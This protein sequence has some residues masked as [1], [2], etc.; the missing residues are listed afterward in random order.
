MTMHPLLSRF[1]LIADTPGNIQRLR[2]LVVHLAISGRLADNVNDN[3]STR[4]IVESIA[5]K[6]KALI[7]LGKIKKQRIFPAIDETELPVGCSGA[8]GFER[9]ENIA[10]LEKGLTAIQRTK[11][12]EYPLVTTGESRSNASH[13]D[14][15]GCAAIIP[16]VSSTGHGNASLK[17][18]HYQEGKF[19]M[20]NILCAAFPI[21]DKLISAR[22]IFEYLTA[23]KDE[24][25]VSRMIGT[26][27]VS[28]TLG[29]IG[30]VPIPIVPPA[31]QRRVDELMALCDHFE[32]ALEN[33]E[34]ARNTLVTASLNR[35]DNAEDDESLH[36][37]AHFHFNHLDRLSARTDHIQKLR[38]SI[39]SLAVRGRLVSQD[40]ADEPAPE[41]LKRIDAEKAR[42]IKQGLL[43]KE[44][45]LAPIDEDSVPFVVPNGW[46]WAKIGTCSLLT[47]YGTSVRSDANA[48][49]VPVLAMGDIQDGRVILHGRKKVPAGIDDL[50]QLFLKRFDLLYNRTNSAEL[51]GKTGIFLGSDDKYTFA[52]YL[53]RIRFL[54][55]LTSPVYANL[56]M[57]A[58]YFRVTQIV[59]ELQ[60]QCG[61]ANVNGTKLRNMLIPFPPLAEQHRIVTKVHELMAI[62]DSLESQIKE[63]QAKA[64]SLLESVLHS[65]LTAGDNPSASL[66]HNLGTN[67]LAP[68]VLSTTPR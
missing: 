7:K 22:F 36:E 67:I 62:C 37:R 61:Q 46:T 2:K 43:R 53:I 28:L 8:N 57:N 34:K 59:P 68:P 20:G 44:K 30:E 65:T 29:K 10:M 42:L 24:L 23:F 54:N 41:L 16:M 40:P 52:S 63:V 4:D 55:N 3:P 50:P 66:P 17:R 6:K 33:R 38:E 31:V 60:Q 5:S 32:E 1:E 11:P 47:E 48:G 27:N 25:L 58:P 15:D 49:G 39:L 19:A 45:P 51:V 26:A 12:G 14:F 18:L 9:L 35:L 13:F 56:A 64:G 21:D